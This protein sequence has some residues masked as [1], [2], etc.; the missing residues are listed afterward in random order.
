M[1]LPRPPNGDD[2]RLEGVPDGAEPTEDVDRRFAALVLL[3][4]EPGAASCSGEDTGDGEAYARRRWDSAK[5]GRGASG[6]ASG[7]AFPLALVVL[8]LV[9]LVSIDSPSDTEVDCAVFDIAFV[10]DIAEGVV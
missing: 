6:G 7:E 9:V 8:L 3:L 5:T 2:E 4:P 10:I 1:I